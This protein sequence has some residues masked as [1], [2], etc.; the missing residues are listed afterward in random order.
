MKMGSDANMARA[1]NCSADEVR[2]MRKA[3]ASDNVEMAMQPAGGER[4][5]L[6][7]ESLCLQIGLGLSLRQVGVAP[8]HS[9]AVSERTAAELRKN[10]EWLVVNSLGGAET[11]IKADDLATVLD[12]YVKEGAAAFNVVHVP[13][14]KQ[15]V[16]RAIRMTAADIG[17]DLNN[18]PP[19]PKTIEEFKAR[20]DA[21]EKR[22]KK[23]RLKKERSK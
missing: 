9:L 21:S 19:K 5:L 13:S 16:D 4:Q 10:T 18:P 23:E 7:P 6:Y 3:Y 12:A 2:N 8:K 14:I 1:F 15:R 17:V 20:R 11:A 22:V